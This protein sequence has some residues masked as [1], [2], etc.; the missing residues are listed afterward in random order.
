M[1]YLT[2]SGGGCSSA[3]KQGGFFVCLSVC[4]FVCP[5]YVITH[6][7]HRSVYGATLGGKEKKDYSASCSSK[8]LTQD[9]KLACF[10]EATALSDACTRK[11]AGTH[12][13]V[14]CQSTQ[15]CSSTPA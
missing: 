11:A 14:A 4:L 8:S 3:S 12:H 10:A 1:F 13:S 15:G 5:S 2:P 6:T 7:A 9:E